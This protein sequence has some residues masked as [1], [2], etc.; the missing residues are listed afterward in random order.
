LLALVQLYVPAGMILNREKVLSSGK[1]YKFQVAPV[2][3]SDP[4][5]GKYITLRYRHNTFQVSDANAWEMGEVVFVHLRRDPSGFARI[6]QVSKKKP[7]SSVNYV[8]AR[9]AYVSQD[10][11]NKTLVVDYPFDR[12]YMEESKALPA[13]QAYGAS[14]QDTTQVTYALVNIK[15]GD[16][17][18]KDVMI[19]EVPIREKVARMLR[20]R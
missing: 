14:L 18:L 8:K 17:V 11:P 5:R 19:G 4:F 3:P 15:A 9:V 6:G 7:P 10:K 12:Y 1:E 13:E 16:A 20:N 2:D